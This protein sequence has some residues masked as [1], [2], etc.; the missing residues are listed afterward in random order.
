MRAS[1]S[2]SCVFQSVL[3]AVCLLCL[4]DLSQRRS[5]S[6]W[7]STPLYIAQ[8]LIAMFLLDLPFRIYTDFLREHQYGL[9]EQLFGAWMRDQ[10]VLL[11][12]NVVPGRRGPD[13]H[14]RRGSPHG[15]TLV[16]L[17]HRAELRIPDDFA[18]D[19]ASVRPSTIE[20]L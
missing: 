7:I 9:T 20:R 1:N 11:G 17:G 8:F 16:A 12:V 15:C 13:G 18:A 2:V 14:L 19:R 10:V 6:K 3:A 4:S 5:R